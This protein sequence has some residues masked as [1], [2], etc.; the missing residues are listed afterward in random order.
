MASLADVN[1]T[2]QEQNV[3]LR[4]I[5]ASSEVTQSLIL[6]QMNHETGFKAIEAERERRFSLTGAAE[7]AS[8]GIK[9][10]GQRLGDFGGKLGNFLSG[11]GLAGLAGSLAGILIKRGIPALLITAFSNNLRSFFIN[12]NF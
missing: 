3:S 1:Q 2:L 11:A 5:A 6:K 10:T 4:E 12:L 9:D 7:G 8:R